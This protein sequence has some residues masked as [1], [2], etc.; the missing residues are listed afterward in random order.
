MSGHV[1]H[2]AGLVSE[3]QKVPQRIGPFEIVRRLGAGGMAEAFEGRRCGPGGFVQRVCVKRILPSR[4]RDPEHVQLFLREARLAAALSH[5]NIVRVI[6][7]GADGTYL[8][9]ELIEGTDLRRLLAAP[10]PLEIAAF[11]ASEIAEA[12]DHAHTRSPIGPVVHRDVTPA[13]VLTS[14]EGDVKLAD[15]GIARAVREP[16][17]T[18]AALVRGN[19]WHLAPEQLDGSSRGD[20]RSDL[21]SLGIVLFQCISGRRPYAGNGIAA[22]KAL[23]DGTRTPLARAAPSAPRAMC[24]IVDRLLA[25]DRGDRFESAAELI[26]ALAPFIAPGSRRQLRA[27]V[28][29][30]R[31]LKKRAAVRVEPITVD[32]VSLIELAPSGTIDLPIEERAG[33][34]KPARPSAPPAP[35]D[36]PARWRKHMLGP[37]AWVATDARALAQARLRRR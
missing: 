3:E 13:N 32:D 14:A 10:I 24:A 21:F 36:V 25:H 34:T 8:A 15:F 27:L 33:P 18:G 35:Q 28:A 12:L 11:I 22:M 16:A 23:H 20:P 17:I 37:R 6:E 1:Q 9:L 7:L 4:A 19:I 5:R 26:D 29:E 31:R 2:K 30:R